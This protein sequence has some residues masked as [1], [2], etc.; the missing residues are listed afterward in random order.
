MVVAQR[1]L[2][3]KGRRVRAIE[4]DVDCCGVDGAQIVQLALGQAWEH[5]LHIAVAIRLVARLDLAIGESILLV[6]LLVLLVL[7]VL[8]ALLLS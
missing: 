5:R 4:E 8:C 3:G 2:D 7:I 1:G 6:R